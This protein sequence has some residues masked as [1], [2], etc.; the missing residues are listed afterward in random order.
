MA[1]TAMAEG[2]AKYVFFFIGDGMGI[3]TVNAAET[4]LA[5]VE[6]RIGIK[7]LC[8]PSFPYSAYINTYSASNGITD[9]AAAGTA[10]SCGQKTKNGTEGMLKDQ[11]TPITSISDWAHAAGAAV[12]VAT[13]VTVD[14]ATPAAFYAH[15]ANR[16]MNYEIGEQ[17]TK[18]D[19]DFFAGSDFSKPK[20]PT[21]GGPDL[22]Q[23]AKDKGYTIARG[24]KDYQ[25][26][27]KKAGKMILLQTEEASKRDR[28][29]I[30]Y[31]IDRTKDDLSLCDIT[32]A[33][34]NF[35][36]SKQ[37]EKD[38]F[39]FMVEGGKIDYACHSN[40]LT[41]ISELIDMDDA[42]KV[43]YEF[44]QQH[45][46]ETLIVV[47]SDH[48]T[49]GIVLGRGSYNLHL[50]IVAHQRMSIGKLGR[51]LHALHEKQGDKYNWELVKNFLTENFGFWDKVQVNDD[52]TKR[53]QAA[54]DKIMAG[55]GQDTQTLYQ[56]DDELAQTVKTVINECARIGWGTTSH[57][58]SY[59][60]CFAAGAGAEGYHG[61]M[62]NI[63]IPKVM[64]KAA[65]WKI[66]EH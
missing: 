20:N 56:R 7:E 53:L 42:V 41:F 4:Y 30:P 26:K 29:S 25:K 38:G 34:I 54:F 32:R 65:G 19:F 24:Y 9:S 50:D 55:K 3:N 59:V 37:G 22:Y 47:A 18:S 27:A 44:L 36:M 63:E 35:L 52:Q 12:G 1:L 14:H 49:G 48:D 66:I 17:L 58:N 28:S 23:Q 39:F 61:R 2:R 51:E 11:V 31:A 13:S 5:A 33:G 16:G 8:F 64:A 6:G 15:V 40:E 46:D 57:T 60:P 45:P 62:D 21:E 43:A 10:L